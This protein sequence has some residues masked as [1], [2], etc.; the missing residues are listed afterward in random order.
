MILCMF[1]Y[2][3]MYI[4]THTYIYMERERERERYVDLCR[5]AGYYDPFAEALSLAASLGSAFKTSAS[6][7]DPGLAR[8]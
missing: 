3:H 7:T 5:Y 6:P 8:L 4:H 2:I 1:V